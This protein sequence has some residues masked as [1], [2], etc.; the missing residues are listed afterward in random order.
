[1][2]MKNTYVSCRLLAMLAMLPVAACQTTPTTATTGK[3]EC[4]LFP[5]I[6][7][8]SAEDSEETKVQIRKYN[9]GRDAYCGVK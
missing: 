3:A 4:L 1:M 2:P 7:Y 9:A 8:S 5:P 6:T